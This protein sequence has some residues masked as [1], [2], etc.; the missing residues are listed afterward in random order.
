MLASLCFVKVLPFYAGRVAPVASFVGG[1]KGVCCFMFSP[2]GGDFI[3]FTLREAE[4]GIAVRM[5]QQIV[6]Q[7]PALPPA[8]VADAKSPLQRGRMYPGS[9]ITTYTTY[10]QD[11]CSTAR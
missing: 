3:F 7:R 1:C 2:W 9:Y 11:I 6:P 5:K 8:R 10:T 4:R